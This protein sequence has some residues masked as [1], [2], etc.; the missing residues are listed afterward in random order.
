MNKR[1]YLCFMTII[2]CMLIMTACGERN[3]SAQ[4]Y[5]EPYVSGFNGS[6]KFGMSVNEELK[7]EILQNA[8]PKDAT[9]ME[10]FQY[11]LLLSAMEYD[12]TP[13]T[14]L[15]NG[16]KVNITVKCDEKALASIKIKFTDT[17]FTYTV[18]GL[19][20]AKEVD[21]MSDLE[22][23]YEG[24][25]GKATATIKYVGSDEFIKDNAAYEIYP[26]GS[27]ANGDEI[28]PRVKYDEKLFRENNY[29]IENSEQVFTV[30]GLDEYLRENADLSEIDKAMYSYVE[31]V[32]KNSENYR[33]GAETSSKGFFTNGSLGEDY[34]VLDITITPY[35]KV[36]FSGTNQNEYVFFYKLNYKVEK[37]TNSTKD[38]HEQGF[39]G[40]SDNLWMCVYLKNIIK[41][42]DGTLEYNT[43]EINHSWY[44]YSFM[45]SFVGYDIDEIYKQ[46]CYDNNLYNLETVID[47]NIT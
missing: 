43:D 13:N 30:S 26:N 31:E 14:D 15:S 27:L 11:E 37:T 47:E 36:L 12:A 9:E 2:C 7:K 23:S 40:E 22:V 19:E 46:Y 33:I 3:Y 20:D 8:L 38:G 1:I 32:E 34:K 18:E 24:F 16:D 45:R 17:E 41:R 25:S 21:L 42:S 44:G 28:T 5:F 4:E 10:E 39:V 35:R 6:G 29:I